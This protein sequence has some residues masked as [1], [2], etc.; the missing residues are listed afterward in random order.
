[1]L[2]LQE[3]KKKTNQTKNP[4]TKKRKKPKTWRGVAT[5]REVIK[6]LTKWNHEVD[7]NCLSL[8]P[9]IYASNYTSQTLTE[10]ARLGELIKSLNYNRPGKLVNPGYILLW[11]IKAHSEKHLWTRGT[12]IFSH[13]P[14]AH[15][16]LP[17]FNRNFNNLRWQLEFYVKVWAPQYKRDM[18]IYTE[19]SPAEATGMTTGLEHMM[20]KARLREPGFFSLKKR[21]PA[22]LT[23]V[24]NCLEKMELLFLEVCYEMRQQKCWKMRSSDYTGCPER[25]FEWQ[26]L[27]QCDLTGYVLSRVELNDPPSNLNYSSKTNN[28]D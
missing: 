23:A 14:L 5:T 3:K 16:Q 17:S 27:E 7:A 2:S 21:R 13:M 10:K 15:Y 28:K 25:L 26:G 22:D 20:Y 9:S 24:Y 18:D 6:G 1:M 8:L 11:Y 19:M 4:T 12:H